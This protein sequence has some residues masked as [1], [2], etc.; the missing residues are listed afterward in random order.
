MY[1]HRCQLSRWDLVSVSGV[2]TARYPSSNIRIGLCT[3]GALPAFHLHHL[4][5]HGTFYSPRRPAHRA[6]YGDEDPPFRHQNCQPS[7]AIAT[8]FPD[9][10]SGHR[11]SVYRP[12]DHQV[13]VIHDFVHNDRVSSSRSV[14]APG[15]LIS[16]WL[17]RQHAGLTRNP[18]QL[19]TTLHVT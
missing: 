3:T 1:K 5:F 12:R 16:S 8:F 11:V 10:Q 9:P 6:L 19:I 15:P 17:C 4:I 13:S 2:T 7:W 14:T 18:A